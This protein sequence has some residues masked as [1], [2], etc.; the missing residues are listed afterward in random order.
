MVE[1][2]NQV[3]KQVNTCLLICLCKQINKLEKEGY[4]K[5]CTL[6]INEAINK[7]QRLGGEE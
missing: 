2:N 3:I 1:M 5:E 4:E 6:I 7:I